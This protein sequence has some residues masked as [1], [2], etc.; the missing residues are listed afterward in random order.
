MD[1]VIAGLLMPLLGTGLG[2]A[3]VFCLRGA[4]PARLQS[5]FCGLA[6]GIMAAAS[7]WSLLLPALEASPALWPILLGYGF[8]GLLLWGLDALETRLPSPGKDNALSRMIFAVTLHNIPEGMAVG[9]VLASLAQELPGVSAAGAFSLALG[10]AIQNVP[11]GAILSLPLAASGTGRFRAFLVGLAS[12]VVEPVGAL[13]MM[14]FTAL[15]APAF[16][17]FL[18]FA[19][20]AM[21]Y[22]TASELLPTA[23]RS[24]GADAAASAFCLGFALMMTLDVLL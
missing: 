12:G 22:V 8:G 4:L 17:A 13:A 6:G 5:L 23:A 15:L 7:V 20:G 19:A 1:V 2:A 11:E 14:A 9:L 24:D 3:A 10:I 21:L 18:A 16:P